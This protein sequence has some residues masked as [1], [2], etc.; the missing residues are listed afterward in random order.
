MSSGPKPS[1]GT[2]LF[3]PRLDSIVRT[4]A[5]KLRTRLAKYYE[6]EGRDQHLRIGFRK[7][8][9]VPF[10]YEAADLGPEPAAEANQT[11]AIPLLETVAPLTG[12][13]K[14]S[15]RAPLLW[16]QSLGRFERLWP[17]RR[18]PRSRSPL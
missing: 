14:P 9:Y 2:P 18:W 16:S 8:S 1:A 3:D 4:E 10:V 6:T 15:L 5:R 11:S 17:P 13:L 12:R 7:G